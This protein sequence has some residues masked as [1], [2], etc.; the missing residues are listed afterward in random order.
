MV[1]L[2]AQANFSLSTN[3][4]HFNST[5]VRLKAGMLASA[6]QSKGLFQFH[7]GTIKSLFRMILHRV[8]NYF[9]STMV[10]LKD[11]PNSKKCKLLANFNSTMVRLKALRVDLL[12]TF[13]KFQFHYGTIKRF[14]R[15]VLTT[16]LI[17]FNSTMVRLKDMYT[18]TCVYVCGFN[19]NS[20]MVRLKVQR[21]L[22][23]LQ[24]RNLFQFHYGTI[25]S[26]GNPRIPLHLTYFNSTMVRLKA[27][28]LTTT[29][30]T[31]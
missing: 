1:R 22:K 19:F 15:L 6:C 2:K 26:N 23:N 21:S 11:R 18:C 13:F 9:N 25:K 8:S 27:N 7:Y 14:T 17:Y 31:E 30:K 3:C 20:T 16:S 12:R 5:M 10:R 28:Y 29:Y 24:V 4:R